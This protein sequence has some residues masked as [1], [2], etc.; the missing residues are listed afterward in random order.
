MEKK[1]FDLFGSKYTIEYIDKIETEDDNVFR[2]GT[3]NSAA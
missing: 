3:T 2:F 1:K